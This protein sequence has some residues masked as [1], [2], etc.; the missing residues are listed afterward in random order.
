MFDLSGKVAIVT[1]GSRGIG[2][3]IAMALSEFGAKIALSSRKIDGLNAVKDKI[4]AAGGE[5]VCIPANMGNIDSLRTIVDGTLDAF[6][7]VDILVNN[8]ATNP[9]FGPLMES[10][11]TRAWDKIMDVNLKGVF[12]LTK[13]V[14]AIMIE[15]GGGSII[16]LSTEAAYRPM[17]GLGIYSI[18]KAGLD[19]VTKAFAQE[20]GS[21]GVRVNGIAPGLVRTKFSRAL[22]SNDALKQAIEGN[23]PLGRMAQPPEMAGLAVF[24]ASDAASYVTGQT[25]LADGG[26][27][28]V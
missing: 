4:E 15:K 25:I 12:F 26:S 22:W 18:S 16:N 3:A 11:S 9:I 5:A 27:T 19:M 14:A 7:T 21:K 28:L 17:P 24:L 23:I 2:E 13:A 20:L 8:A 10:A 6:G 1:G